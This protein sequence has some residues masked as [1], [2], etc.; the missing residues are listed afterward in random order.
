M[1][2]LK[3][4]LQL[5]QGSSAKKAASHVEPSDRK[6]EP[7]AR[8]PTK[9]QVKV[10]LVLKDGDS[11][12]KV[13]VYQEAL[14]L[15]GYEL[16]RFGTDSSFGNEALRE[17]KEFQD[18]QGL[19]EEENAL[20]LG[21]VGR[22][23]Y[24]LVMRLASEVVPTPK[25]AD[26]PVKKDVGVLGEDIPFFDIRQKHSGKKRIRKRKK[27]WR[28]IK[29]ITLHQTA[30]NMSDKPMR[31]KNMAAHIAVTQCGNVVLVNPLEWVMYHGN[32]FNSKDVGIEINGHFA[33]KE[34]YDEATEEWTPNL[35]YYWKPRSKPNRK[36]M[37]VTDAQVQ[38]TLST[39][40]WIMD[41]VAKRGGKVEYI[42]AHRQSSRTKTS[43][44]GEK[45]WKLIA[46]EAKSRWGLE[47]GG[48]KFTSGGHAIPKD[49][50]PSYTAK[51]RG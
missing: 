8:K 9:K 10:E 22:Q 41:E 23:T 21:G 25:V 28:S 11:G 12:P 29:G 48:P 6:R 37:S 2:W 19:A 46:M 3:L 47:D 44:P 49:W 32:S 42:H 45:I 14:E 4:L 16:F 30:C 1:N 18:D 33:G 31:Y 38:G 7:E 13:K 20:L 35:K 27:G 26:P 36:P 40:K 34:D 39:I 15:L 24:E 51:Y 50:D 17:T 43:D 5:F